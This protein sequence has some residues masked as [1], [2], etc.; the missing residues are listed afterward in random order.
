MG[1]TTTPTDIP[2]V[3]RKKLCHFV[4]AAND[5]LLKY[6]APQPFLLLRRDPI[7][8]YC[9]AFVTNIK[10]AKFHALYYKCHEGL[11]VKCYQ[12]AS[13]DNK[14]E[15]LCG[16]YKKFDKE[17]HIAVECSSDESNVPE[18]LWRTPVP[19]LPAPLLFLFHQPHPSPLDVLF[20]SKRRQHT[21]DSCRVAIIPERR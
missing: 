3:Q 1:V 11:A 7:F 6:Y 19:P 2:I 20:S 16:A 4:L 21:G 12:C 8:H 17:R 9:D 15:D 14:K 18:Y 13:S 5:K 10:A